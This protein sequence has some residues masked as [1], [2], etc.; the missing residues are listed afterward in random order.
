V[1]YQGGK[2]LNQAEKCC[3][4]T[5]KAEKCC[6]RAE[7]CCISTVLRPKSAAVLRLYQGRKRG[8]KLQVVNEGVDK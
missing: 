8:I 6:S 7:K 4:S 5:V 2:V 1:L 3:I